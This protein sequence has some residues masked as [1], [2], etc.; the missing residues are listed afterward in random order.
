VNTESDKLNR[1]WG[2]SWLLLCGALALHVADEAANDFLSYY[3]PIVESI[4]ERVPLLPMPVFTF[5]SWI[6]G[7]IVAVLLLGGC[8]IFAYAGQNWMRY[9]SYFFAV[10]M[11]GNG[12]LHITLSIVFGDPVPGVWSSPL[13]L[14]GAYYLLRNTPSKS[15]TY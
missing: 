15:R 7:L 2:H 1:K 4:A 8:S 11:A 6:S 13:L 14:G 10:F 5:G 9:F 3:N 12:L